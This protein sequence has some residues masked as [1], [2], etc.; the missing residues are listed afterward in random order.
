M[1]QMRVKDQDLVVEQVVSTIE[2]NQKELLKNRKDV[3]AVLNDAEERIEVISKL[4][5]QYEGLQETIKSEKEDLANIVKSFQKAN[6]FEN[7][8]YSTTQGI[9]LNSGY[10]TNAVPSCDIVWQMPYITRSKISTKLRLETMGGD[11]DVYKIIEELTE[12]FSS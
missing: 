5:K 2:S 4:I 12:E 9:Q 6:E 10:H 8:S 7:D 11:F 3:Q 1:A